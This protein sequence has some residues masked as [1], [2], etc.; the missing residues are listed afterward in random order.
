MLEA[1]VFDESLKITTDRD[2]CIRLADL[3]SVRYGAVRRH[4]VHH[5]AEPDRSRLST[6]SG[7]A[8]RA[9]LRRFFL[10][11]RGRMSYEQEEA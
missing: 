4:L 10:K 9:G 11:Y 1:G 5:Y 6:R 8:K 3:C 7:A 2:I